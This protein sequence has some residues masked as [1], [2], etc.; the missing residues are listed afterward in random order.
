MAINE[1]DIVGRL[2]Q[3]GLGE[4]LFTGKPS[5]PVVATTLSYVELLVEELKAE[6][7]EQGINAT[8]GLSASIRPAEVQIT[9]GGLS[10]S[11]TADDYAKFIDEGVTGVED[12]SVV[13]DYSFKDLKVAPSMAEAI[14]KWI[15]TRGLMVR[16]GQ[17]YESMSY[18][19]ATGVKKKGI[20]A[21]PFIEKAFNSDTITA[22]QKA[23]SEVIGKDIATQF[24]KYGDNN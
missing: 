9:E 6:L 10:V 23:L 22:F 24:S 11:I 20:K 17:T 14:R 5:D 3:Q 12:K 7:E 8:G 13:S 15:P 1:G 18:A 16:E 2:I 21:R 19:I 4:E